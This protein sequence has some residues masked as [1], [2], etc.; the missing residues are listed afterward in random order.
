M[1]LLMRTR[2]WSAVAE[3]CKIPVASTKYKLTNYYLLT[4]LDFAEKESNFKWKAWGGGGL[5]SFSDLNCQKEH[6]NN[7]LSIC[8][9]CFSRSR[10]NPLPS[11]ESQNLSYG[12]ILFLSVYNTTWKKC[13]N[14][15][16]FSKL[17]L[18]S[19]ET[20]LRPSFVPLYKRCGRMG[21][22]AWLWGV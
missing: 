20:K 1:N 22:G 3:P 14:D 16:V 17:L 13:L 19:T 9:V 10:P 18:L 21:W 6:T 15:N 4:C 5:I 8:S 12:R 11:V 7:Y 2:G